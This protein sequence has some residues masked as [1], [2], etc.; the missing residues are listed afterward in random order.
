MPLVPRVIF[1]SGRPETKPVPQLRGTRDR[2]QRCGAWEIIPSMGKFIV[3]GR[4]RK[5]S[6]PGECA[7]VIAMA[8]AAANRA[9]RQPLSREKDGPSCE[10]NTRLGEP[11]RRESLACRKVNRRYLF[12]KP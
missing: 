8:S 1:V 11:F 5:G 6:F 2:Y 7:F 9:T 4:S 12:L 3:A 10:G